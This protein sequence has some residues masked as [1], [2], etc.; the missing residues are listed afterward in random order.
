MSQAKNRQ[1]R[2]THLRSYPNSLKQHIRRSGYTIQEFAT[3]INIPRS[4]L[5]D[6]L[7]GHR[8]MPRTYLQ[9]TAQV[10]GCEMSELLQ[11]LN[12]F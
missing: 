6:Y 9:R 3:E 11:C 4:T 12:T 7:G 8:P 10:L 5:Y 1:G 2:K